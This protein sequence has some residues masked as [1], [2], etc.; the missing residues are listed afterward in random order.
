MQNRTLENLLLE[1]EDYIFYGNLTIEGDFI[2]KNANI[3]V[4][5]TLKLTNKNK[6]TISITNGNISACRLESNADI[7]IRNGDIS[8]MFLQARNIDSDG[9]ISVIHKADVYDIVCFN[10]LITGN[11]DS[12]RISAFHDICI[13]GENDSRHII[14]RYVFVADNCYLNRAGVTA[15]EFECGG[16]IEDCLYSLIA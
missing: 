11:N 3:F 12:G 7:F 9:T 8:V 15:K 1:N 16:K 5:G 13:L 10:Y 14:G 6:A 2:V 4:S